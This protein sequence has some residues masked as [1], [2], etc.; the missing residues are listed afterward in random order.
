MRPFKPMGASAKSS[1]GAMRSS[2]SGEPRPCSDRKEA[3]NGT[4][5]RALISNINVVPYV[6][7]MLVL[8]VIFMI[9]APLLSQGIAIDL[10]DVQAEPLVPTDEPL[11]FSVDGEGRFYLNLGDNPETPLDESALR[12]RV[13]AV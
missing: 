13:S 11:V 1:G 8:L 3:M 10:P 12:D 4:R 7:V 6:D 9:T 2:T 5:N